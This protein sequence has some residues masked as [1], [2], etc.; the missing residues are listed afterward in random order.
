[1]FAT[2]REDLN[3]PVFSAIDAFEFPELHDD[4]IATR[5]FFR[6]LSK[7]MA[8]CGVKDFS[9]KVHQDPRTANNTATKAP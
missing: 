5:N 1:M 7:L 3:Q 6:H 2:F 9:M 8:S 4:S